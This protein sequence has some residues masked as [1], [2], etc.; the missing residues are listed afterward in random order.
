M[1]AFPLGEF[2][3]PVGGITKVDVNF[4]CAFCI[5]A[6]TES[7]TS[8]MKVVVSDT[9]LTVD[10]TLAKGQHVAA[11][12]L[13]GIIVYCNNANQLNIASAGSGYGGGNSYFKI[14]VVA[15]GIQQT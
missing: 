8:V 2:S 9:P 13:E 7:N 15:A 1:R 4:D 14:W 10:D 12:N 3:F 5:V 11:D 6:A